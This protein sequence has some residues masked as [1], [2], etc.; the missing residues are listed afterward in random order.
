MDVI[1]AT[2]TSVIGDIHGQFEQLIGLLRN[3]GLLGS[4]LGWSGGT[5]A[6]WLMGDL[7]DR[8]PYGIAVIDLV[9]RLQGEATVAG[10]QVGAV[11]GNHE[12]MIL[13]AQRFGEQFV[14]EW[15]WNGGNAA[16]LARLTPQHVA[17]MTALPAM[18]RVGNRLLMHADAS[19]YTHY[20]RSVTQVNQAFRTI[21]QSHHAPPWERL[22]DV[23][24]ERRAFVSTRMNGSTRTAE[25]VRVFGARQLIHGHTPISTMCSLSPETSPHPWSMRTAYASM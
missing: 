21:L 24:S 16:D 9:M 4:N 25:F 8:R 14:S 11:L 3:A 19:F 23:F 13:A 17:W 22:V 2:A 15:T 6:V 10:G 20:G 7:L 1:A 5:A 12:V 18:V